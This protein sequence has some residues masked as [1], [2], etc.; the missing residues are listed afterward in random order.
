MAAVNRPH[1][2]PL[3][4]YR[5]SDG[6]TGGRLLWCALAVLL[7]IVSASA[8]GGVLGNLGRDDHRFGAC[9]ATTAPICAPT[10]M[11]PHA[12]TRAQ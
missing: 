4:P 5:E 9:S 10:P 8:V 7:I 6:A 2:R 11:R 12:R 1:R 3:D